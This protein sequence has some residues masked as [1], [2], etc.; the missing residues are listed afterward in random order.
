MQN[1]NQALQEFSSVDVYGV[2]KPVEPN[3]IVLQWDPGNKQINIH[4]LRSG[5]ENFTIFNR[6]YVAGKMTNMNI[7]CKSENNPNYSRE[8]CVLLD[9]QNLHDFEN[10]IQHYNVERLTHDSGSP[11]ALRL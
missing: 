6:S 1:V 9:N 5:G 3:N 10:F 4:G 7:S 11:Y 2:L 8:F